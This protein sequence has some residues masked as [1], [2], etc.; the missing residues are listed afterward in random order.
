MPCEIFILGE[1]IAPTAERAGANRAVAKVLS[2]PGGR[3]F[4]ACLLGRA[5][6]WRKGLRA[7]CLARSRLII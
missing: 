1:C 4:D 5:R 6:G 3:E 7:L 2:P